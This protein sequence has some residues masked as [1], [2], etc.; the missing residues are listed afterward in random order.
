VLLTAELEDEVEEAR[1]LKE[2]GGDRRQEAVVEFP[3]LG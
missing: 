2:F 3:L 1:S